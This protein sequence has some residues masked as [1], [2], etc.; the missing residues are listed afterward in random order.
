MRKPLVRY[1]FQIFSILLSSCTFNANVASLNA[2]LSGLESAPISTPVSDIV[3]SKKIFVDIT[4]I[5][6]TEGSVAIINVAVNPVQDQDTL[7]NL[8]LTSQSLFVRFNP[9]PSQILIPAGSTSKS[10]VLNT[11]DDSLVEDQEIWNFNISSAD[12]KLQADPG[13]LVIPLNDNDGGA[14]PNT[15]A[16]PPTPKL[17]AEFNAYP[18]AI[19]KTVFNGKVY[20]AGS[21]AGNGTEL[22]V[23]DGTSSGTKLLKDIEP[24]V[25]SS[26]PTGFMADSTNT[27]L[28]F[29]AKTAAEGTEVWRTDGTTN[30]TILL[31]DLEPGAATSNPTLLLSYNGKTYFSATT[32]LDGPE[33]YVTDGSYAG[34]LKLYNGYA[35]TDGYSAN[36]FVVNS[37]NVYFS[38]YDTLTYYYSILKTDGTPAGTSI[39]V[40]Q[41]SGAHIF[42]G[43]ISLERMVNGKLV[44]Q[45]YSN[46][47]YELYATDGTNAGTLLLK[48][49]RASSSSSYASST[50]YNFGTNQV[51]KY[52]YDDSGASSGY[53]YFLTDGTPTGTV[54]VNQPYTVSS[55]FGKING[56]II[57]SGCT[58][59]E[60]ELVDSGGVAGDATLIKDTFPGNNATTGNPNSGSPT[61]AAQIGNK[62]F[63]TA[64][65]SSG[66]ELWV[67]DGTTAGTFMLNDIN[68]GSGGSN[69][70]NFITVGTNLLFTASS[71]VFGEEV[72]ISDG[73]VAGTTVY[74]DLVPGT[75]GSGPKNLIAVDSTHFFLTAF[76]SVSHFASVFIAD[77]T[78]RDMVGF[79]HAMVETLNSETK[80]M[81]ALN[82]LVY[83]DAMDGNTGNPLWVTDGTTIG[84]A[85]IK[86][87]YPNVVCSDINYLTAFNGSLFFLASEETTGNELHISD[88]TTAGTT[89][90]KEL[91]AGT[92][93]AYLNT[94]ILTTDFGKMFFSSSGDSTVGDELYV[95][96]GTN[97]GT[98]LVKD[99]FPGATGSSP[100]YL[101]ALPTFGKILFYTMGGSYGYYLSN[102]TSAGTVQLTGLS[103]IYQGGAASI[104][105]PAGAIF[106]YTETTT[107]KMR[108]Y[109]VNP[110]TAATTLLNTTYATDVVKSNPTYDPATGLIYY[111]TSDASLSQLNLWKSD[112][113][114]AGTTMLKNIP[115]TGNSFGFTP[116]GS[117]SGK[118]Y[119][120]YINNT[121]L[122]YI[123]QLWVTDG[124][125]AGSKL[126]DS[127]TTTLGGTYAPGIAFGGQY[128]F[129]KYDM[130]N[131]NELWKTD[132]SAVNTKLVKDINPGIADSNPASFTIYNGKLYFT[133]TEPSSGTELWRTDGT[134]LG[135]ELVAD[136]NPG[137]NSS[138]PTLL[139][140][141]NGKLYFLAI[142][143][144]S[145][146]EVWVYSE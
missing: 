73:T 55:I 32:T 143:V 29:L 76:N 110:N 22:W 56:R 133:A 1:L 118:T 142:K 12:G 112:G 105:T 13:T 90:L 28:Y 132:G 86:D 100:R 68:D 64:T 15:P 49:I 82:G 50:P 116:L 93:G 66:N 72:W 71:S 17:L 79:G 62:I 4:N 123:R 31:T 87:L 61:F 27:Y 144:L 136:I 36:N 45:G 24:G 111:V 6:I 51:V 63:F 109:F 131:G 60:C 47:G 59:Y 69:P 122:P 34:T 135:T 120:A 10:V 14:I 42:N 102:G 99:I 23:S 126:V 145:G 106:Y 94:P 9:I 138:S 16:L 113:T 104:A 114:P 139:K 33:V 81:V 129:N 18:A 107:Y 44:F 52:N 103:T 130:T 140:V 84:T 2:K 101:T 119:F 19:N 92:A 65:N 96:D 137:T 48:D 67:S 117:A 8:S 57:F 78:V 127:F 11:I 70:K 37:G 3:S 54:K 134:L 38:I 95:S 21:D 125:I 41:D 146:K 43:N 77:T 85:K 7:I 20:Y 89:I 26:N 88:G 74:K 40:T 121:A 124:T 25:G 80:N 75:K 83:F 141:L 98:Q 115:I 97:A 46:S 53:G 39:V 91:G 35:G 58:T 128:Y 30:G 5:T 108:I